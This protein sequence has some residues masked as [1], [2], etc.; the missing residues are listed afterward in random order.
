MSMNLA[1]RVLFWH[2]A[3]SLVVIAV[4]LGFDAA[5]KVPAVVLGSGLM[6]TNWVLLIW[7]W[8]QIFLKKSIA[9]GVSVIVIK[10]AILGLIL[11]HVITS[12]RWDVAGFLIGISTAVL[13]A[14]AFA[15]GG[16]GFDTPKEK[17]GP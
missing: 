1:W 9:L 14:V 8:R 10:Y 2:I 11:Y 6:G 15:L 5:Q 4:C 16:R 12:E 13:T 17:S 7:S 3:V